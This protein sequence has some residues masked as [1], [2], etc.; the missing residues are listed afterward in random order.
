MSLCSAFHLPSPLPRGA[1]SQHPLFAPQFERRRRME[2]GIFKLISGCLWEEV[3]FL[4]RVGRIHPFR[5]SDCWMKSMIACTQCWTS[6]SG[7]YPFSP[8]AEREAPGLCSGTLVDLS[9]PAAA[10]FRSELLQTA[11]WFSRGLFFFILGVIVYYFILAKA[12]RCILLWGK[13]DKQISERPWRK[14]QAVTRVLT[15]AYT[16]GGDGNWQ[17]KNPALPGEKSHQTK[18]GENG[19]VVEEAC[20]A[21][22]FPKCI[23]WLRGRRK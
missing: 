18:T 4:E 9:L 6:C 5:G 1:P 10:V 17:W 23:R 11:C 13:K 12:T 3:W 22:I 14:R 8:T 15:L 2:A 19:D 16:S 20:G 7:P 21:G